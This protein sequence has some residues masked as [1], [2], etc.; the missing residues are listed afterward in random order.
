M[1]PS[2]PASSSVRIVVGSSTVHTTTRMPRSWARAMTRSEWIGSPAQP[3]RH[4]GEGAP[5][6][7]VVRTPSGRTPPLRAG[8]QRRQR[9]PAQ[10]GRHSGCLVLEPAQPAA[11]GAGDQ[12]P[13]RPRRVGAQ[14][15]GHR[16]DRRLVLEVDREP[17]LRVRPHRLRQRRDLLGARA[18]GACGGRRGRGRRPGRRGRSPVAGRSRGSRRRARRASSAR[19]SRGGSGR[20]RWPGRRRPGC[21]RVRAPCHRGARWRAVRL[22]SP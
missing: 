17:R 16:V 14:Q 13:L 8:D 1:I 7:P 19:R 22:W 3:H 6:R 4:V 11:P 12:H 2:T 15:P 21:S 20:A 18:P 9:A 10:R 5:A